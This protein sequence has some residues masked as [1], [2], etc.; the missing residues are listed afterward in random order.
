MKT[1]TKEDIEKAAAYAAGI[2][3]GKHNLPQTEKY[4][5][6][7]VRDTLSFVNSGYDKL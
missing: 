7:L 1:Y 3:T 2:V 5:N 6:K 4:I